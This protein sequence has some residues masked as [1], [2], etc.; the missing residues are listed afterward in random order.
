MVVALIVIIIAILLARLDIKNKTD[1]NY[2]L[3]SAFVLLAV[4]ASIRYNWG[5][6]YPAY[7]NFFL[8]INSSSEVDWNWYKTA[9]GGMEIGWV[10]INRLCRPI[11]FFGMI[12]FLT[13]LEYAIIYRFI[14]KYL[15]RR[16]YWFAVLLFT[17]SFGLM[18]TGVSMMRQFLAQ[19]ICLIAFENI[20]N[21]RI[22]IALLLVW[23]ATFFHTSAVIVFPVCFIGYFYTNM[24]KRTFGII[25]IILLSVMYV[26]GG[27]LLGGIFN[28]V[29][30]SKIEFQRYETYVGEKL[31]LG[32]IGQIRTLYDVAFIAIVVI[33]GRK[34]DKRDKIVLLMI[35][36][37]SFLFDAFA[38][39]VPLI[40][41][42][43]F[44]FEMVGIVI[45][46]M[47]FSL[48]RSRIWRMLIP[49]SYVLRITYGFVSSFYS[50]VWNKAFFEYHTIFEASCWM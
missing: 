49:L 22:L 10:V 26:F 44:Y 17:M 50:E 32:V 2:G 1:K 13:C 33:L 12:I 18:I 41:R 47:V 21:K 14:S 42:I 30:Q 9:I 20:V 25:C 5:N 24:R 31:D 38:N 27:S 11:G 34:L 8:S 39:I 4:F 7:L 19:C 3:I 48:P 23:L 43:C 45:L 40:S 16:N 37:L 46:P 15:D 35:Y 36:L 28:S 6:D 29:F